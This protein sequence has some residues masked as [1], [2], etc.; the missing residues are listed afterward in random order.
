MDFPRVCVTQIL[1]GSGIY[2]GRKQIKSGKIVFYIDFVPNRGIWVRLEKD[3]KNLIWF[4]LQ[5]L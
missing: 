5:I 2:R 1:R 3:R 4:C